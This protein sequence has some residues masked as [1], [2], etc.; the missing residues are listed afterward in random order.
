MHNGNIENY[1]FTHGLHRN[2]VNGKWFPLHPHTL[3]RALTHDEMDY[4]LLYSQQT[5]AGWRIFGQNDN[6]TISDTELTKSLIFWK[7]SL[8]DIDYDRYVTAGYAV[9]QYIWITPLFDC[10]TFIITSSSVTDA[11]LAPDPTATPVPDPTATPVPDPTATEVPDPT[12]T[13]DLSVT[14]NPDPDP[15]ATPVP[16]P[17]ATE[18]IPTATPV[19]DP[20]ATEVI[21]TAT[22]VPDP[23]AT[24]IPDPTAT[25]I[26]DPTATPVP[27]P[28]ATAI[29][30]PTATAIPDPTATPVPDPT[31]TA[32]PD[33]TATPFPIGNYEVFRISNSLINEGDTA[34]FQLYGDAANPIPDGNTV[35]Y[36]LN[37]DPAITNYATLG[38]DFTLSATEFTMQDNIGRITITAITDA[39]TES[40]PQAEMVDMKTAGYDN[41][42]VA[43]NG[44][45]GFTQAVFIQDTSKTAY[46]FYINLTSGDLNNA[47]G[48][49]DPFE[50]CRKVDLPIW[51]SDF[52]TATYSSVLS[53]T[54]GKAYIFLDKE[55]TMPFIGDD[56]YFEMGQN[57]GDIG[58]LKFKVNWIDGTGEISNIMSC[59]DSPEP[60]PVVPTSTPEV[61]VPTSTPIPVPTSTPEVIVPTSTPIPVPTS[62]PMVIVPTSTPIPEPSSY[63]YV[64]DPCDGVSPYVVAQSSIPL[65]ISEIYSL[66]GIDYQDLFYTVLGATTNPVE[67]TIGSQV[68]DCEGSTEPGDGG[69][70]KP[71]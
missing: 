10:D 30:D 24:A 25:A 3:G 27:D 63:K 13:P 4:N 44:G 43:I 46:K 11:A 64:M 28:T 36:E 26:P 22:P 68:I 71:T 17:T 42:G 29:P 7:I 33:P 23:T 15:T 66:T 6:L 55:L 69:F 52:S 31:A 35:Q 51:T 61:I 56:G 70:N 2:M 32:I 62:T 59:P 67:T 47:V 37:L 54:A 49:P 34:E 58:A 57:T 18:V 38:V 14:P 19:P 50:P 39:L 40:P 53:A 45:D 16:D 41:Q 1:S 21:P 12:A 8:D 20:T 5:I 48:A 60:T 65:G 9:N